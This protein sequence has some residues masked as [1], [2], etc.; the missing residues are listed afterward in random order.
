MLKEL[1]PVVEG[2]IEEVKDE[3][4]AVVDSFFVQFVGEDLVQKLGVKLFIL[5]TLP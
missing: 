4:A 3:L 1:Y 2:G 5:I